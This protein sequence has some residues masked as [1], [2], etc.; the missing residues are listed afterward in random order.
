MTYDIALKERIVKAYVEKIFWETS[1]DKAFVLHSCEHMA[2]FVAINTRLNTLAGYDV[3]TQI[4]S[5]NISILKSEIILR[6]LTHIH[7]AGSTIPF[8]WSYK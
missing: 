6:R 4:L 3:A 7:V 8:G 5:K 1:E 2:L